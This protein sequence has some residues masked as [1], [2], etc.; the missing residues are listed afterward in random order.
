MRVGIDPQVMLERLG[1]VAPDNRE[2]ILKQRLQRPDQPGQA[3]QDPELGGYIRKTQAGDK[4]VF[5]RNNNVDRRPNENGG[6]N[7]KNLIQNGVNC[8]QNN[9]PAIVAGVAQQ[10]GK[11]MRFFV[12]RSHY[13][14]PIGGKI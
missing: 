6:R 8:R 13:A 10:A 7:I 11:G 4:G 3:R 2:S 14:Y 1:Q 9:S 5:L 12:R